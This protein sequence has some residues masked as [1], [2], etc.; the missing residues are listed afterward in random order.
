MNQLH[1]VLE[2]SN[3]PLLFH[4]YLDAK[5][6]YCNELWEAFYL[7]IFNTLIF[8]DIIKYFY[9]KIVSFGYKNCKF[10]STSMPKRICE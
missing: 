4:L 9:F 2:Y 5:L 10:K 7:K 8:F 1:F 6:V 3:R